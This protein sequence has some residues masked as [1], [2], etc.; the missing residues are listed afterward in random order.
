ME[1]EATLAGTWLPR[2]ET[3][4]RQQ[5]EHVLIQRILLTDKFDFIPYF[6]S[7]YDLFT[8]QGHWGGQSPR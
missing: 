1:Q 2:E 4:N 8:V 5:R 3:E 6:F 7:P